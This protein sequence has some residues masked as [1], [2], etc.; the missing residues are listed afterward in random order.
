[1]GQ[2]L[3]LILAVM[4]IEAWFLAD[5]DLFERIHP[6]AAVNVI[7]ERLNIDLIHDDPESYDH[8]TEILKDIFNL[9]DEKYKKREKQVHKIAAKSDYN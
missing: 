1:M 6:I 9:F 7:R 5:C 8:P 4:E 3:R 2:A